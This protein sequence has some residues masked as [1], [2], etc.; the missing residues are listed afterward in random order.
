MKG[1]QRDW[2]FSVRAGCQNK[3]LQLKVPCSFA[4]DMVILAL[5]SLKV[6]YSLKF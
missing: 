6:C 3:V 2:K 4:M 1:I 5:S